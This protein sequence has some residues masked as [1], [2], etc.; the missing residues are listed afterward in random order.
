MNTPSSSQC[1]KCGAA[2]PAGAPQ[3]ICPRC[4]M[5]SAMNPTVVQQDLQAPPPEEI[6]RAF[7]N[8]EVLQLIG[9]GGMGR[10]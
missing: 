10:V 8:L 4:L 9:T 7:P 3:G 2:I 6:I 5:Q 1:P